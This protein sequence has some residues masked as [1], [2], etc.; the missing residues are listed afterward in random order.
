MLAANPVDPA[1]IVSISFTEPDGPSSSYPR[2]SGRGRPIAATLLAAGVLAFAAG[3]MGGGR[4]TASAGGHAVA[5]AAPSVSAPVPG[6]FRL[7]PGNNQPPGIK[8]ELHGPAGPMPGEF[9]LGP[10]NNQPPGVSAA[11]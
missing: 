4:E 9:R 11:R 3:A 7:G 6:E 1:R 2:R 8:V 10:G 5:K